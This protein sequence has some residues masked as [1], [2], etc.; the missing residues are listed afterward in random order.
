MKT[1]K[2]IIALIAA[3]LFDKNSAQSQAINW[4]SLQQ[5][6]KHIVNLNAGYD[7]G[8][9]YG[10]GYG[11]QLKAKLPF[12][13]T[14]FPIVLGVEHSQPAGKDLVDDFK[15]KIGGQIRLYEINNFHFTAKV[16]GLFRRY[17]NDYVRLLN[18]GS[19]MSAIVGYYKAKWFVSGEFGFDKAIV[20]HFKHSDMFKENFP[21]VKNGWYEPATGGNF[22]YGLQTGFS[23]KANDITL[24]IG[25]VVQQDFKTE[26]MIP[27]YFQ[28]GYSKRF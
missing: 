23:F 10:I 27:Y 25:K 8:F 21:D 12:L 2:I 22:Y 20:T 11:H 24:K 13:K 9:T 28:V 6:Q 17:E 14:T 19:D 15:T 16:Q 5:E 7:F 3:L 18:F 4:A 1:I 26:P